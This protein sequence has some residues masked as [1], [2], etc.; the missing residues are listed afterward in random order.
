MISKYRLRR[1]STIK[2][3]FTS[4]EG[5]LFLADL[6]RYCRA[7]EPTVDLENA[8]ATYFAEGRRDVWLWIAKQLHLTENDIHKLQ[9]LNGDI[10]G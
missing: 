5:Q 2:R 9:Q 7:T 6:A 1:I 4:S 3:L 10:H 8:N